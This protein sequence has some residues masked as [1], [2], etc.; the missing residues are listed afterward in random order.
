MFNWNL[1]LD[2]QEATIQNCGEQTVTLTSKKS[3]D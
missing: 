3:N 1:I 2:S